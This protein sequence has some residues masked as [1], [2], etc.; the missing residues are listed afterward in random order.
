MRLTTVD[1][2]RDR[3]WTHLVEAYLLPIGIPLLL[4][5]GLGVLLAVAIVRESW[6][7]V[8]SLLLLIPAAILFSKYPYAS[9]IL[10]IIAMPFLQT[11]SGSAYRTLFWVVHRA[12]IP[13]ALGTVVINRLLQ[14]TK[15]QRVRL[16]PAE[17]ATVAYLG[18]AAVNILVSHADPITYLYHCY[19][20][21]FLPLCL[22][23]F[24]RL[25]AP[26]ERDLERLIPVAFFIVLLES[27]V[28]VL[29][30]FVPQVL[31][32][33]W[34]TYDGVRTTGTL[35]FPHVYSTTLIFFSLV[36]FQ[37][38]MHRKPGLVRSA[39][40]VAFGLGAGGVFLSYSRGSWLGGLVAATGLLL[41]YPKV[42]LRT[43]FIL[44]TLMVILGSTVL[45]AQ[46][47]YAD[48]RLHSEET[49]NGRWVLWDAGLQMVQAK[50]F[51]GWGYGNY[52]ANA[53]HFQRRVN[54]TVADKDFNSHN[55][56]IAIAAELGVPAL[57]LFA[58]PLLWWMRLTL[59]VWPRMPQIGFWSRSLLI[60]FWMVILDH[61]TTCFFSDM[62]S[63]TY[64]MGMWWITLGLI[65]N[66]VDTYLTSDDLRPPQW[67]RRTAQAVE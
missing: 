25:T 17:F 64:G 55:S 3:D 43:A 9:L 65:G 36:L 34:M 24:V 30:Q 39:S 45:S 59:K 5:L 16:G 58:F 40:L 44:F 27:I 35:A 11:P 57:I 20:V 37:S 47:A 10:W 60:V 48:R 56:Y 15:P 14:V 28:G 26:R 4:G 8:F 29:S 22:Y 63:S 12:I 18:L 13:I 33:Q 53:W 41:L 21:V 52:K 7:A 62:R 67:V 54:N 51:F 31:P 46:M 32:S 61:I 2:A 49:A 50:P 66:M 6:P 1:T 19:D 42:I 23:W 38:A